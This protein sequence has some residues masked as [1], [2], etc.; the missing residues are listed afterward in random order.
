MVIPGQAT[1]YKIGQ[2]EIIRLR[3]EARAALGEKFNPRQFHN[4]LLLTGTVPLELLDQEVA[5]WTV[6]QR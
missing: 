2:L 3:D 4:L 6:S 5:A 1:S